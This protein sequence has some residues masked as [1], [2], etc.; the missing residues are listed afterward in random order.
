MRSFYR[1]GH[2]LNLNENLWAALEK[3]LHSGL[4]VPISI[5]DLSE[6]LMQL[7]MEINVVTLQKLMPQ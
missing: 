3:T 4:T 1:I 7:W 2:H 6:K 5:Q